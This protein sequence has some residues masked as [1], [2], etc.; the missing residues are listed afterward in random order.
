MAIAVVFATDSPHLAPTDASTDAT[1]ELQAAID[2][3]PDGGTCI[4]PPVAGG[5]II[6]G[7]PLLVIN[8]KKIHVCG[9]NT[10]IRQTTPGLDVFKL[11]SGGLATDQDRFADFAVISGFDC[12]MNTEDGTVDYSEDYNRCTLE[13]VPI[14]NCGVVYDDEVLPSSNNA[15]RNETWPMTFCT[16]R[17][18]VFSVTT[19]ST[20]H[21]TCGVY[22]AG[23]AYGWKFINLRSDG[24]GTMVAVMLPGVRRITSETGSGTLNHSSGT[25]AANA[26]VEVCFHTKFGTAPTGLSRRTQLFTKSPANGNTQ[27]ALTSGGATINP[28]LGTAPIY[29]FA[30]DEH[31][32]VFSPDGTTISEITHYGGHCVFSIPQPEGLKVGRI[33]GYGQDAVGFAIDSVASDTVSREIGLTN[34]ITGPIYLESPQTNPIDED[35]DFIRI[36]WKSGVIL[37]LQIRGTDS[38]GGRP[39]IRLKGQGYQ[40]LG[41]YMLSNSSQDQPDLVVDG[42]G[43]F[44][45]GLAHTSCTVTSNGLNNDI[46]IT[47]DTA[48]GAPHT[49]L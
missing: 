37:G 15:S 24:V 6:S 49:V 19:K 35:E 43:I 26:Q 14:G 30:V 29:I 18:M 23:A 4:I 32:D 8:T 10:L 13:G 2:A 16:V 21:K 33:D 38:N 44:V 42:D 34:T 17:D 48:G 9:D 7:T 39:R 31:S 20:T 27:L 1:A 25:Y 45:R 22:V 3:T 47:K 11:V 46:V 36:D 12:Q 40:V 5:Y 41:L 28:T